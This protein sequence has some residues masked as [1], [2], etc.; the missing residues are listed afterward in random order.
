MGDGVSVLLVEDEAR[1]RELIAEILGREG[2]EIRE[3]G[4]VDEALQ[5]IAEEVPDLILCDW[6]MPGRDG[7]ELL[8]EVRGRAL[9]CAFIVMTAGSSST[10]CAGE[11]SAA[12]S[13]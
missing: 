13:S 6:R 3:A 4:T 10:R 5:A 11:L 2:H 1:Q 8:D 9:G 12:R 7:G